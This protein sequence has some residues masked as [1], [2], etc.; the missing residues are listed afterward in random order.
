MSPNDISRRR[1]ATALGA[2]A[3]AALAGC[4]G[5]IDD[6][7]GGEES[8]AGEEPTETEESDGGADAESA[9][10]AVADA[11]FNADEPLVENTML[12]YEQSEQLVELTLVRDE[13]ES[14]R[15][16]WDLVESHV[17]EEQLAALRE[18]NF[19]EQFLVVVNALLPA[20]KQLSFAGTGGDD[21]ELDLSYDVVGS[22]VAS[23]EQTFAGSVAAFSLDGEEPP[24][25][26][27]VDL[28]YRWEQEY[29]YR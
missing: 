10:S 28:A 29:R 6:P 1:V 27:G 12:T 15:V 26:L 9:Y 7:N 13:S 23:P 8:D 2:T 4:I 24:T 19:E 25:K 18:V 21:R 16:R 11:Q 5:R 17:D 22:G 14:E 20:S 3:A